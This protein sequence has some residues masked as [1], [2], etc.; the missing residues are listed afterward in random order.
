[1][2]PLKETAD[3]FQ[4][5]IPCGG[6]DPDTDQI[7][8]WCCSYKVTELILISP[9]N[10]KYTSG[11]GVM[12]AV[13]KQDWAVIKRDQVVEDD[14][15]LIW[16]QYL[17]IRSVAVDFNTNLRNS[18]RFTKQLKNNVNK[19]KFFIAKLPLVQGRITNIPRDIV[20]VQMPLS[21]FLNKIDGDDIGLLT[22][23]FRNACFNNLGFLTHDTA[24]ITAEIYTLRTL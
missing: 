4:V 8:S 11:D 3:G 6:F 17:Q 20:A 12:T 9:H 22:I 19:Q 21:M 1:M 15:I 14:Y 18:I 5:F 16:G 2:I 10:L 24:I 7:P 13:A 23:G